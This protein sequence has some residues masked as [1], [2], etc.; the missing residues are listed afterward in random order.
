ML[1]GRMQAEQR[2]VSCRLADGAFG[3]FFLANDIVSMQVT[4]MVATPS[5]DAS[6]FNAEMSWPTLCPIT[7]RFEMAAR[8]LGI[9]CAAVGCFDKESPV[10]PVRRVADAGMSYSGETSCSH[11][12]IGMPF[13]TR[14][15]PMSMTRIPD[16]E[17]IVSVINR[18]RATGMDRR[19]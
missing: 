3:N 4:L 19:P 18:L 11:S 5:R 13:L 7:M 8:N 2:I 14:I 10:I 6:L 16:A 15:A 12:Q 17:L 9:T 1:L